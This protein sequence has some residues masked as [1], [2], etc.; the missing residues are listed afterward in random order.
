MH[1]RCHKK[2]K[3]KSLSHLGPFKQGESQSYKSLIIMIS[4]NHIQF[5][6]CP[7]RQEIILK[8]NLLTMKKIFSLRGLSYIIRIRFN[9]GYLKVS[10]GWG[11]CGQ[12]EVNQ[13]NAV[14]LIVQSQEW[15]QADQ[16]NDQ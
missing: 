3:K 7:T 4:F 16:G 12:L 14:F 15:T 9:G 8:P 10:W 2:Q 5:N 13:P 1:E 11:R 6:P